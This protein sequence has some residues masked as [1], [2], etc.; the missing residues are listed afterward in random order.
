MPKAREKAESCIYDN[1]G[2]SW[3]DYLLVF[4]PPHSIVYLLYRFSDVAPNKNA[5]VWLRENLVW[6][7]SN[8]PST[9]EWQSTQEEQYKVKNSRSIPNGSIKSR[10]GC[11]SSLKVALSK[12]SR[13]TSRSVTSE[14]GETRFRIEDPPFLRVKYGLLFRIVLVIFIL[15]WNQIEQSS[16]R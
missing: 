16:L 7:F 14:V 10:L 3:N 12:V 13:T 4:T 1:L 9:F 11:H 8:S 6:Q 15:S 5:V 2:R